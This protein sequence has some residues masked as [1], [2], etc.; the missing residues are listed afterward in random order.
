MKKAVVNT[1]MA[2]AQLS[3]S[4]MALP[5]GRNVKKLI[6]RQ[7]KNIFHCKMSVCSWRIKLLKI[8]SRKLVFHTISNLLKSGESGG[9][10]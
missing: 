7:Y 1:V 8:S 6:S 9:S 2:L 5:L 10:L 3:F 4:G